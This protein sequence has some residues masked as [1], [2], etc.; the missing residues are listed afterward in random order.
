MLLGSVYACCVAT[1]SGGMVQ[2]SD[3]S[4]VIVW[5]KAHGIEHFVRQAQF[6]GDQKDFGFIVPTPAE[7]TLAQTDPSVFKTL[8]DVIPNQTE[9]R[10]K[11]MAGA[12]AGQLLQR[13]A[14]SRFCAPKRWGL[15]TRPSSRLPTARRSPIG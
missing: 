10:M 14:P 4:V 8:E 5:D 6:T 12:T 1:H 2:L 9:Q 3:E 15:I 13:G 11:T 7:P